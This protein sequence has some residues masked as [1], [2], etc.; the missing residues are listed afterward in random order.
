M[1]KV[2]SQPQPSGPE[3]KGRQ[4]WKT[5]ASLPWHL[6]Y[7]PVPPEFRARLGLNYWLMIGLFM[8]IFLTTAF[9]AV[10]LMN[11]SESFWNAQGAV[12]SGPRTNVTGVIVQIACLVLSFACVTGA[13]AY[14]IAAFRQSKT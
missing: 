12:L 6:G 10:V 7:G 11:V 9:L 13:I 2:D 8:T 14:L 4:L 3:T 1:M 5:V